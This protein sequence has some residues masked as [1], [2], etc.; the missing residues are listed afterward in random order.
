M[1]MQWTVNPPPLARLVRSQDTPPLVV[2]FWK[3]S[4]YTR[5]MHSQWVLRLASAANT[6]DVRGL[7]VMPV[8]SV[9]KVEP[10]VATVSI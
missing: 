6:V 5:V 4:V 2:L 9:T 3:N 8:I 7:W 10:A 1:V